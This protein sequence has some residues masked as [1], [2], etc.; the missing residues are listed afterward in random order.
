MRL[1]VLSTVAACIAVACAGLADAAQV[2]PGLHLV[3]AVTRTSEGLPSTT[4]YT[5]ALSSGERRSFY[6]D[7]SEQKRILV[8]IAGSDVLGAARAIPPRD[9]YVMMGPASVEQAAVCADTLTRL[10]IPAGEEE[11]SYEPLFVV[12]LCFSDASPYGLWNRAPIFAVG[13][14][15]ERVAL[16]ALRVGETKLEGPTVRVLSGQGT[17]EWQIPLRHRELYV[18]DLAWSPDGATLAYLV[19][20]IGDVHTL[21]EALLPMAGIY[22][23][24]ASEKTSRQLYHCYG[25]ALVWGPKPNR[26]TVAARTGDVWGTGSVIRVIQLPA[27][28]RTEEFSVPG[29]VSAIAYSEDN[30]WLVVQ[31]RDDHAQQLWLYASEGGY[32]RLFCNVSQ[33]EGRLALLG[34][35]QLPTAPNGDQ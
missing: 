10:R 34:W 9:V 16:P 13:G 18:A 33:E 28:R 31:T 24:R 11:A 27:G 2:D 35:A 30:Q 14:R 17:E 8:K 26:L 5:H 7:K 6:H 19:M 4:L 29:R 22:V 15:A 20:P 21:D 12:P 25:D 3:Y 1:N 32:G 23:A